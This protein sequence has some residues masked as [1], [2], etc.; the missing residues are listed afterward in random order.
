MQMRGESRN[1]T[2]GPCGQ[3]SQPS[4]A[5]IVQLAVGSQDP[6]APA[7]VL[8]TQVH[9]ASVNLAWDPVPSGSLR[10]YMVYYGPALGSPLANPVQG[11]DTKVDVGNNTTYTVPN[12]VEGTTYRFAVTAYDAGSAESGFSNEVSTTVA[13]GLPVAQFTASTTS[14]IA[15]LAMNFLNT[16]TGNISTYAWTFGDGTTSAVQSPS[17]VY[18][19]AG[20]YSVS[21]T[22]TGPGGTN[23]LTES[24][25]MT[26]TDVTVTAP[27]TFADDFNR[28]DAPDLGTAWTPVTGQLVIKN[29]TAKNSLQ[30]GRAMAVAPAVG[31]DQVV[32]ADFM[33]VDNN[34][35]PQF[36]LLL[37]YQDT[38]NFYLLY[39]ATGGSSQ[40]RIAKVVNGVKTTIAT[41]NLPNPAKN[42]SF[43][44]Q[45]TVTGPV[46][47]LTCGTVQ[48]TV[49]D[50]TFLGTGSVGM[51]LSPGRSLLVQ[52]QAE[53]FSASVK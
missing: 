40:L 38:E 13:F 37:R 45:G 29:N 8:S 27:P 26:V 28:D 35:G 17:H 3:R 44:L 30:A 1:S 19:A 23:T 33:S 18:A 15:P 34:L 5:A 21:L 7:A 10:G 25:Y 32:R 20:S 51:M 41:T 47:T 50:T 9:A 31:I 12:L 49:I 2:R 42:V 22:V 36:G 43:H 4:F 48:V 11:A 24:D 53:N 16:S 6:F 14:G 46:L 52:H 39:R